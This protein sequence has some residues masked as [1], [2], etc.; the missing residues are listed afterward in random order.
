MVTFM[1]ICQVLKCK[2]EMLLNGIYWGW[3][4]RRISI[5]SIGMDK[6]YWILITSIKMWKSFYRCL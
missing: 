6:P 2:K 3:V 4:E 1:V 5:P